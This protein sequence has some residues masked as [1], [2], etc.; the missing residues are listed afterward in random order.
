MFELN[1]IRV[2][3]QSVDLSLLWLSQQFCCHDL[4]P[5]E[6]MGVT[7]VYSA[8]QVIIGGLELVGAGVI[9]VTIGMNGVV[10]WKLH[11]VLAE[12][13]TVL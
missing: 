2:S 1:K 3:R 6:T 8:F 9:H 7:K 10:P 5:G 11:P 12:Q 4:C 13:L